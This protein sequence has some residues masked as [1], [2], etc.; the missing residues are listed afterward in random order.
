VGA[1]SHDDPE[2]TSLADRCR[3]K[4]DAA[5]WA[6]ERERLIHE[7]DDDPNR[8]APSDPG[9][10]AWADSLVDAYHWASLEDASNSL[11]VSA[12]DDAAGCFE[13]LAEALDLMDASRGRRV[14]LERVLPLIAE[15]QS[16]VRRALR[17]INLS[18]DRDQLDAYEWLIATAARHRVFVKRFL[19]A[20]DLADPAT[21]PER[22]ARIESMSGGGA[23]SKQ[24]EAI[25][26]DLRELARALDEPGVTAEQWAPVLETVAKLI[27][28]GAPPSHREVR[29]LLLPRIDDMPE[30]IDLPG[31]VVLVLREIDRY[32]ATRS[33]P[34]ARTRQPGPTADVREVSR[35]L[36]GRSAVLIGG[37]RRPSSQKALR[38]A[39][40]LAE[41][42][43]I[44]TREH[45]SIRGF[46]AAIVRPEVAVVLLAIRWSS[47]SF[48]D[49]KSFCDQ[50]SKPLVRLPGG[51]NPSQVASQILSQCSGQLGG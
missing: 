43:W 37:L 25:L 28:A 5:R 30:G 35:L 17:R 22:L 38:E 33:A 1:T 32:L 41:L 21:W 50:S 7:R 15:A 26:E 36:A 11:D 39:F 31:E 19:K 48:G 23:V 40:G 16:A 6:A 49:V 14:S 46:E 9:M 34:S 18:D 4:A 12:I 8:G 51:Y 42:N 10:K 3:A 27:D 24:Q 13:T 45:E 47:H 2:P 44:G 20:D 29:D